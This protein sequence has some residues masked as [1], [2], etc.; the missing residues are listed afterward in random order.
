MLR[1]AEL[2]ILYIISL[3]WLW[4]EFISVFWGL[5]MIVLSAMYLAIGLQKGW[6]YR[7]ARVAKPEAILFYLFVISSLLVLCHA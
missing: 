3:L 2:S 7:G 6:L 5:E 4:S 1:T